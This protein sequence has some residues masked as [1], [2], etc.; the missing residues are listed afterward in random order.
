[1]TRDSCRSRG[2][3]PARTSRDP[4]SA[5]G[6]HGRVVRTCTVLAVAAMALLACTNDT[7]PTV[8]TTRSVDHVTPRPE[9]VRYVAPDGRDKGPGTKQRPWR[10]L[11]RALQAVWRGQVLY[12][13]GGVY[14][15]Q[16][17]HLSLH[18]GTSSRPIV[19]RNFPGER[20]TIQGN[21][22]LTRPL[23]WQFSG[24]NV[25]A[26]ASLR[27]TPPALVRVI[28]GIGWS[29]SN[30]EISGSMGGTNVLVVG[31][32]DHEPASWSLTHNCIH[33]VNTAARVTRA[34][35]LA[36][37]DM[38]AA[39]PGE[40]TRNLFFGDRSEY[41]VAI[42]STEGGGPSGLALTYNTI[43]GGQVPILLAGDT[44]RVRIERNLLAGG[45]S[46]VLIRWN[47]TGGATDNEVLQNLG[48]GDSKVFLRPAAESAVGGVGNVVVPSL[49]FAGGEDCDG[50]Q[51][52]DGMALPYGRDGIG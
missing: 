15:E 30:S 6:R 47:G 45:V 9:M 46:D 41:Q 16:L 26:D 33:D 35:N 42:G 12:V 17:T 13:R 43:V 14:Q 36:L 24:I 32:G 23:H 50:F 39:G 25:T 48:T 21:I 22:S 1:M 3:G 40:V 11:S 28:G 49:S 51:A 29:W 8:D 5:H 7:E 2:L 38:K 4:I 18:R 34:S 20:P 10:T 37:A 44:S 27:R 19:V 31:K 52:A